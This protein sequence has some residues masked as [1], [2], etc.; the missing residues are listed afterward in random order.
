MKIRHPM[1]LCR[2]VWGCNAVLPKWLAFFWKIGFLLKKPNVPAKLPNICIYILLHMGD[3]FVWLFLKE[4][5]Q[6]C[7]PYAGGYIYIY[8][9]VYTHTHNIEYPLAY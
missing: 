3:I 5:T 8:A 6:K 2:P 7:R 1:H 4:A 9:H